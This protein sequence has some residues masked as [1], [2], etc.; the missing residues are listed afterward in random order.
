MPHELRDSW[1]L[2]E[3]QLQLVRDYTLLRFAYVAIPT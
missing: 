2:N 3:E 1:Q